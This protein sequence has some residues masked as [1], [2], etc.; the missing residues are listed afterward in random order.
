M[1]SASDGILRLARSFDLKTNIDLYNSGPDLT[2]DG[3]VLMSA[4]V[5]FFLHAGNIFSL[6]TGYY[7]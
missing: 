1:E 6:A 5:H 4:I 3:R 7:R 2:V